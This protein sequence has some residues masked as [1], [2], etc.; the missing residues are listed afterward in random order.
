MLHRGKPTKSGLAGLF[1]A[2]IFSTTVVPAVRADVLSL[3]PFSNSSLSSTD[4]DPLSTATPIVIGSGLTDTTRFANTGNP[5]PALRINTDET[6]GSSFATAIA[7]GDFFTFTLAPANGYRF[8]FQSFSVD[9]ATNST[10]FSTNVLLQASINGG[11]SFLNVDSVTGFSNTTYTTETFDLTSY[12]ANAALAAGASVLLRVVVYDN[13]NNANAYT[14]F[15][16]LTVN[17]TLS[18]I[19]EPG[20][21]ALFAVGVVATGGAVMRRRKR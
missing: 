14:G 19:P 18:A 12:N 5:A 17:G 16:N 9:L 15:D 3:Y 21:A 8:V 6:G 13:A 11:T 10:A 2:L 4:T 1:C 7:D 20:T